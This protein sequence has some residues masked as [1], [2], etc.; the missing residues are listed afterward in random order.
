[1]RAQFFF[2]A[3]QIDRFQKNPAETHLTTAVPPPDGDPIG[4]DDWE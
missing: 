1:M 4:T 3:S 2:A